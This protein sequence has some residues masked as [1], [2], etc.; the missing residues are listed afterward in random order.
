MVWLEIDENDFI[1]GQHSERCE[2][3]HQWVEYEGD[4]PIQ[5]GDRYIQG[6]VVPAAP[7]PLKGEARRHRAERHIAKAYSIQE[8]LN[9]LRKN[10]TTELTKMNQFMDDAY[11]W[12]DNPNQSVQDLEKIQ[13]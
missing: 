11:T 10:H 8:Q 13:P 3:D 6:Q 9:I 12:A 4:S 5:P 1:V 2:S 7:P